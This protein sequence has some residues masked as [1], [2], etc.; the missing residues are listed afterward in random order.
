MTTC[1]GGTP[2]MPPRMMPLPSLDRARYSAAISITVEPAISL[3]A[4]TTGRAPLGSFISSKPMALIFLR[5]SAAMYSWVIAA[6]PKRIKR[7][8]P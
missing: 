8:L 3:M 7:L 4:R 2:V 1:D 5:A 6:A